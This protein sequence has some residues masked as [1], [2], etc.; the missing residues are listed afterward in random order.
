MASHCHFQIYLDAVEIPSLSAGVTD[1]R[2]AP[3][4]IGPGTSQEIVISL[5]SL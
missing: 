1:R 3:L 5:C 4:R 2:R